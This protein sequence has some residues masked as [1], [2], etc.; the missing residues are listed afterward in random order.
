MI[1]RHLFRIRSAYSRPTFQPGLDEGIIPFSERFSDLPR[2]A[3]LLSIYKRPASSQTASSIIPSSSDLVLLAKNREGSA[4]FLSGQF[5]LVG[6]IVERRDLVSANSALDVYRNALARE[7]FEDA[8]LAP[9]DYASSYCS[10][11]FDRATG[12]RIHCFSGFLFSDPEKT[13]KAHHLAHA[14]L[15]PASPEYESFSWMP[16]ARVFSSR[17]VSKVAKRAIDLTLSD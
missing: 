1:E 3:V 12:L 11:F 2:E 13:G 10:S 16:V 15:R 4:A 17:K 8:K 5:G 7:A 14:N 6:G 9:S